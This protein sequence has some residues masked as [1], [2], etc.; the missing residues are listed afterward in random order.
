MKQQ[1]RQ[2]LKQKSK[3]PR[4]FGSD[5]NTTQTSG[6][7]LFFLNLLLCKTSETFERAR[8]ELVVKRENV[9][10]RFQAGSR[11]NK[12][13]AL[14]FHLS[15]AQLIKPGTSHVSTLIRTPTS[16]GVFVDTD[17]VLLS[18]SLIRLDL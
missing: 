8:A 13:Q 10:K 2:Q 11:G 9:S 6:C 14:F 5:R 1:R 15:M 4:A 17:S 18:V 7:N 3:K 12:R 16:V